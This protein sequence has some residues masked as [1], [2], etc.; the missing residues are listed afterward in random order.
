MATIRILHLSD[1]Q[2]QGPREKEPKKRAT[3]FERL[4]DF[5]HS[6]CPEGIDLLM[7]SGDLTD[8][9]QADEYAA[10]DQV[11]S[12]LTKRLQLAPDRIYPVP[13]NH[14]FDLKK[15]V[16]SEELESRA[17]EPSLDKNYRDWFKKFMRN[18]L[19]SS[20]TIPGYRDDLTI[21]SV[22]ITLLGIENA[23]RRNPKGDYEITQEQVNRLTGRAGE[24]PSLPPR[25]RIALMHIPLKHIG[26]ESTAD[27]LCRNVDISLCG[28]TSDPTPQT[29][30]PYDIRAGWM[31]TG[32]RGKDNTSCNLITLEWENKLVNHYVETLQ[33]QPQGE[34]WFTNNRS[35][36]LTHITFANIQAYPNLRLDMDPSSGATLLLGENSAGKS[37]FIRTIALGLGNQGETN[38]LLH[39]YQGNWIRQGQSEGTIVLHLADGYGSSYQIHTIIKQQR[40]EVCEKVY[41]RVVDGSPKELKENEFPWQQLFVCGYGAGRYTGSRCPSGKGP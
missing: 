25:L 36:R 23:W 39:A 38:A 33:Y 4:A 8:S 11:L 30:L 32:R 35:L 20:L 6:A 7:I 24:L 12:E 1:L 15:H 13:G 28:H 37:S 14:D 41:Y 10:V 31:F 16:P 26:D 19:V 27:S 18:E 2:E 9:G 40:T 21:S 34:F 17:S 5:L 3:M 29:G 22:P